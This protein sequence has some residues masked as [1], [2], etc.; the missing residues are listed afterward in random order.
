MD[1]LKTLVATAQEFPTFSYT[2]QMVEALGR[3]L[4]LAVTGQKD[5]KEALD[6][7][8]EEFN[9]LAKKDGLLKE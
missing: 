2:V 5:P 7:A 9:K 3:E 8:A 6:Q 4:N 1:K